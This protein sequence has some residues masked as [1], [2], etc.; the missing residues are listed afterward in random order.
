MKFSQRFQVDPKSTSSYITLAST[1]AN[2]EGKLVF[3]LITIRRNERRI[4]IDG[5]VW[6]HKGN[7]NGLW[8]IRRSE[9]LLRVQSPLA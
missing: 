1:I 6:Y 5:T 7:Y 3:T 4:L 8:P 2:A 9:E